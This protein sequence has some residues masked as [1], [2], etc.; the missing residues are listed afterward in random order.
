MQGK[1]VISDINVVDGGALLRK[2][3][4]RDGST[5]KDI[6][7]SYKR[8]LE[9][10]CGK[11]IVVFDGYNNIPSTKDHEH[12]RRS[13]SKCAN[14]NI[15]LNTSLTVSQ[16]VF[17]SNDANKAGLIKL[18]TP[19]LESADHTVKQA[20][21]DADTMIVSTTID[22]ASTGK[23]VLLFA[24]D[25]DVILMLVHHWSN[26]FAPI[27]VRSDNTKSGNRVQKLFDVKE[28]SSLLDMSLKQGLLF[29]HAFSGC[30]TTSAIHDKGKNS[31][32]KLME[33][34]DEAKS[35][36]KVFMSHNVEQENIGKAGV[37]LFVLLYGG[38]PGDTLQTLRYSNYMKMAASS[39]RIIPS[40]LP[41]TERTA[42]FH[43]LRVYLQLDVIHLYF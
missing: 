8:F 10:S 11:S 38:K 12:D 1:D 6:I 23:S 32:M 36:A 43:S 30:D 28:A 3:S 21:A 16:K 33:K 22:I 24:N 17:L 15:Q 41:P 4:W 7:E 9:L 39:S 5:F 42:H 40:K 27:Y 29:I 13:I 35:I 31:L 2:I 37:K 20:V 18:L 25:T 14:M 34:S 19:H 26:D